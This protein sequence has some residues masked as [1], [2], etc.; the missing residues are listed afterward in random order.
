M[1]LFASEKYTLEKGT[2]LLIF[3]YFVAVTIL[4]EWNIYQKVSLEQEQELDEFYVH[5]QI[6]HCGIHDFKLGFRTLVEH[7]FKIL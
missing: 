6:F 7:Y 3:L 5:R 4:S 1:C 2:Y